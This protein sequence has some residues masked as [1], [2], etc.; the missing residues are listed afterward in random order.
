MQYPPPPPQVVSQ[1]SA[2]ATLIPYKNPKALTAYY[3]GVFAIIP[4]LALILGPV[5]FFFGLAGLKAAAANPDAKGKVHAWVG[6]VMGALT[7]LANAVVL[8]LVFLPVLL[9]G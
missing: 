2:V 5:A 6:I 3:C 8:A 1:P 9:R 4:C 7:F